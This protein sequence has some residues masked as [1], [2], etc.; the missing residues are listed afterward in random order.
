MFRAFETLGH[1]PVRF[2]WHQLFS[3]ASRS[4]LLRPLETFV[5]K[6]QNKVIAGPIVSKLNRDFEELAL[7]TEPEMIFVYRGTHIFPETLARL[8]QKLPKMVLVGY[9]NDDPFGS[10]HSYW[11]WRHFLPSIPLYD[12]MLAFRHSNLEQ[13]RRAGAKQAELL[14]AWY[15]P[16]NDAPMALAGA[17]LEKFGADAVFVGHYEPDGRLEALEEAAKAGVKL[18][19]F[20]PGYEWDSVVAGSESLKHLLPVDTVWGEDYRKALCGA[21]I[22]LCFLSKLNNDTYTQRCFEI[23]ASR[24]LLLSEYTDDLATLFREGVEADFF[25]SKE[26]LAAKL[27]LYLGDED[28]RL[29]VAEK[30]RQRVLADGHDVVSRARLVLAWAEAIRL[31][32]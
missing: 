21:R 10:S 31:K 7:E 29:R 8:K 3:P 6:L 22:G 14:R 5:K 4:P 30:G 27:K 15:T 2:S 32:K 28:L 9:N 12:L 17:D 19:I 18:R 23:P 1:A 26:E 24:I 11:L 25:R 13:F 16:W 20:G